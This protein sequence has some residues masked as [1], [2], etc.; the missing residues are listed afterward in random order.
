MLLFKLYTNTM[1]VLGDYFKSKYV[2]FRVVTVKFLFGAIIVNCKLIE[3][4]NIVDLRCYVTIEPC[5]FFSH[6]YLLSVNEGETYF[7]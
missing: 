4:H 7:Q 3:T 1:L 6:F 5:V 2:L